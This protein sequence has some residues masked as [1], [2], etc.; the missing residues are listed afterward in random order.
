MTIIRYSDYKHVI[1][2]LLKEL[3]ICSV[4]VCVIALVLSIACGILLSFGDFSIIRHPEYNFN[5]I[6]YLIFFIIRFF[7]FSCIVNC[8]TFL[9]FVGIKKMAIKFFIVINN[10][11]FFIINSLEINRFYEMPL[12][13]HYY[14]IPNY[15]KNYLLEVT[16]SLLEFLVL[17]W[18]GIISY[19]VL[20]GKKRDL[21]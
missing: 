12:L 9:L 19:K 4:Y 16:C 1:N 15:Y 6:I 7:I 17:G 18:I 21:I 10:L 14:F 8:I 3:I 20:V 13:Y 11:V 5:I 2:K